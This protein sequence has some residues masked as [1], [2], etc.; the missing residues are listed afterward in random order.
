[1]S[2]SPGHHG[3]TRGSSTW[4]FR[5]WGSATGCNW[6]ARPSGG[7]VRP[8]PAREYGRAECRILDPDEPLFHAV[9][10]H[11]TVWMSHGDQVHD[12]GDAFIPLAATATCPVAAVRH[13]ERPVYGLQ[14]HPEVAHTPYGTLIL[15]N[16]LDRIC[17]SPAQLD[18]GGVHRA[19]GRRDQA[20]GR[21]ERSGR[22]RALGRR[23]FGRCRRAAGPGAGA[24]GGLRVRR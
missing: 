13:R 1:M 14:F 5:S 17:E 18:D 12:A 8:N 11:T 10:S 15:G 21:A 23:R 9:P 7:S 19:L 4:V 24:A 22:L 16:F 3:A 2:T 20:P 6:R